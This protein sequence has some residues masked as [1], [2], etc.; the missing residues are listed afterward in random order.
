MYVRIDLPVRPHCDQ[1]AVDLKYWPILVPPLPVATAPLP[2]VGY[3]CRQVTVM[4]KVW[5]VGFEWPDALQ[6][7]H[8]L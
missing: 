6:I 1:E 4:S 8:R 2:R 7:R 3:N 5:F